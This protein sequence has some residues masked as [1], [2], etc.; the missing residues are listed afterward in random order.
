MKKYLLG[1]IAIAMIL[2][3]CGCD[4]NTISQAATK[5]FPYKFSKFKTSANLS[6]A[7]SIEVAIDDKLAYEI[8]RAV[9][10]STYNLEDELDE[11]VFY[12]D[13]VENLNVYLVICGKYGH[14]GGYDVCIAKDNGRIIYVGAGE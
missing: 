2:M 4:E 12:V 9:L 7:V 6:E 8:G 3:A 5:E 11:I 1:V 10:I 13:E 14:L